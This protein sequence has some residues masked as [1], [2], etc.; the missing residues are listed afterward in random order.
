MYS[1]VR[2]CIIMYVCV[3]TCVCALVHMSFM[4][5]KLNS[6]AIILCHIWV[7]FQSKKLK[8]LLKHQSI[9]GKTFA[10]TTLLLLF[11]IFVEL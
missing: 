11:D 8:H 3:H 9:C 6:A 4:L 2:L 7:I 5:D 1:Y 10:V